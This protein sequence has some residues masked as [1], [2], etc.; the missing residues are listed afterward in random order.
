MSRG[1]RLHLNKEKF[2]C[3]DFSLYSICTIFVA[4]NGRDGN[5]LSQR[6]F[7][8]LNGRKLAGFCKQEKGSKRLKSTIKLFKVSYYENCKNSRS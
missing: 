6:V 2:N 1:K 5:R 7:S 3:I 4:G 8:G